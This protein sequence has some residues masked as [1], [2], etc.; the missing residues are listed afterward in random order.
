MGY[1][2][3]VSRAL[4]MVQ[5]AI[6]QANEQ[7]KPVY[8]VGKVIHNEQVCSYLA[9][10]GLRTIEGPN[11]HE[12]GI[13][14]LRAHGVPDQL[15][16]DFQASGY[17]L[18]DATCPVVTHN[19]SLIAS[20]AKDYEVVVVGHKGHP[21]TVAMQGVKVDDVV[22][23]TRLITEPGEVGSP[24][25]GKRY[26]V[27]VQ[28][29]FD[30]QQWMEIRSSLQGWASS[31]VEVYFGNEVC[32]TS[33]QRREAALRLCERCDA[34]LVIGGKES[35]NTRALYNLVREQ[36]VPAWH[37]ADETELTQQMRSYAILG[38]T[39]GASTPPSTIDRV[40]QALEEA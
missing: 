28:T 25:E 37:I 39:A 21:E 26:A 7:G 15:R 23:A 27:F 34:V 4:S 20:H 13:V 30:R 31:G 35:A 29:T 11:G 8:S 2:G 36:G 22:V 1:C 24:E 17:T 6:D 19:L 38:I 9:E 32:P 12:K 3:G 16:E 33:V 10:E 14:V 40:V 18:V 5:K